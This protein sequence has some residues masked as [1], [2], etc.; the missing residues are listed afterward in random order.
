MV[1]FRC[2]LIYSYIMIII[3]KTGDV[4]LCVICKQINNTEIL[5]IL[6]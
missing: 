3:I 4:Y 1:I 6:Y 2:R 5:N